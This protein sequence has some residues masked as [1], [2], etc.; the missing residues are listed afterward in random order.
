VIHASRRDCWCRRASLGGCLNEEE[1][2]RCGPL[3][4]EKRRFR[5]RFLW[6]VQSSTGRSHRAYALDVECGAVLVLRAPPEVRATTVVLGGPG[7]AGA[8][9][10]LTGHWSAV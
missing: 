8:G 5:K 2:G 10:D 3:C 9:A 4:A 6:A 1:E 7:R